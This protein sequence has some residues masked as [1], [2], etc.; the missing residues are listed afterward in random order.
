MVEDATRKIKE[1]LH[2]DHMME[3]ALN[4]RTLLAEGKMEYAGYYTIP[5][6]KK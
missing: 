6:M 5:L 1:K 4:K 2:Q 3:T